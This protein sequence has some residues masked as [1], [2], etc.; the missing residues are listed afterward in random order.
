ML[1]FD[2]DERNGM[3]QI[4]RLLDASQL[5]VQS[6]ARDDRDEDSPPPWDL[7]R[8]RL[9]L[10]DFRRRRNRSAGDS[11]ESGHL[12]VR[13]AAERWFRVDDRNAA[14][15]LGRVQRAGTDMRARVFHAFRGGG[16]HAVNDI[17]DHRKIINR[18]HRVGT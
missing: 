18:L 11:V 15:P 12:L 16:E 17:A 1:A 4:G 5:M 3:R 13:L 7:R 9:V 2:R 6:G 10:A 8:P 14:L